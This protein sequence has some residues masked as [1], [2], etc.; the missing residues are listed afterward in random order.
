LKTLIEIIGFLFNIL[1]I[2]FLYFSSI[3]KPWNIQSFNGTTPKEKAYE[4]KR[5][6]QRIFG[7]IFLIIGVVC[8]FSYTNKLIVGLLNTLGKF[9]KL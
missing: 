4:N 7:A 6:L 2:I 9:I 3:P 1:G 8:M 5:N